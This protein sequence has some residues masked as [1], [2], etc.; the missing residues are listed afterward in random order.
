MAQAQSS[1]KAFLSSHSSLPRSQAPIS[2]NRAWGW[3][4]FGVFLSPCAGRGWAP[5]SGGVSGTVTQR[6]VRALGFPWLTHSPRPACASAQAGAIREGVAHSEGVP[7]TRG[8][9][10]EGPRA[11]GGRFAHG[12]LRPPQTPAPSCLSPHNPD[13]SA[14]HRAPT[15]QHKGSLEA[16][17][18]LSR[19][20]AA[21]CLPERFPPRAMKCL[22]SGEQRSH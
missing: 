22:P 10:A 17:G 19:G 21:P 5:C 13:I 11:A 12:V 3:G 2:G 16:S 15:F 18:V 14:K 6:W 9:G 20:L 1:R 8:A 7:G 4:A